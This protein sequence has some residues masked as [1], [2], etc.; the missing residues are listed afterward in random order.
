M[1]QFIFHPQYG[2]IPAAPGVAYGGAQPNY[3]SPPAAP[4]QPWP[5]GPN[6]I[7]DL[8]NQ[9]FQALAQR[10]TVAWSIESVADPR[11]LIPVSQTGDVAMTWRT[12]TAR[13]AQLTT[14]S[15]A[16]TLQFDSPCV[17]YM[18]TAGVRQA[19]GQALNASTNN[20]LNLFDVQFTRGSVGALLDID[21]GMGGTLCGT[22]ERPAYIGGRA[23]QFDNGNSLTITVTPSLANL[24]IDVTVGFVAFLGPDNFVAGSGNP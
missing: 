22:S 20:L 2:F 8:N 10:P 19:T 12:R 21:S 13:F 5:P 15:Q 7:P 1:S 3:G 11:P 18:R 4:Q 9:T 16:Q 24:I 14:A 17:I 6:A 23:W